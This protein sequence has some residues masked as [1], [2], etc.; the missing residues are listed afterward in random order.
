MQEIDTTEALLSRFG[1]LRQVLWCPNTKTELSCVSLSELLPRL[2]EGQ[3][4]RVPA[5]ALGAFVSELAAV[6]YPIVGGIVS[7]LEQDALRLGEA[8]SAPPHPVEPQADVIKQ[9][10][11]EWYDDF[12]WKKNTN[13][14]Y[15]DTAL[16]SQVNLLG[17]GL[18]EAM[19]HL[20]LVG[21][22]SGGEFMLDAASGPIAHPEKLAYS[23]YYRSRICLDTSITALEEAETKIGA[24]DYCCLA[25]IC[26][27]PFR[28]NSIDGI[29]SGYTIQHIPESQQ[30]QAIM[31]L[32][33]VLRPAA[34]L[35]VIT[36]VRPNM[37]HRACFQC[38]RAVMKVFRI[39]GVVPQPSSAGPR[40]SANGAAP[41][42]SLYFMSHDW[43]WWRQIAKELA[44]HESVECM[45]LFQK[46]EY[47]L[48]FGD[49]A[50]IVSFVRA[51][52]T[53][54]PRLLARASA[55]CL[56]DFAKPPA[57]GES[58]VASS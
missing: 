32:V 24:K 8:D 21:R 4:A 27:L 22:L 16:F 39:L 40:Q 11:K 3:R 31:E 33:R 26:R 36:D 6:A 12:G 48:L 46:S 56:V 45:R 30:V 55:Y 14:K 7:F 23:W 53:C 13:G 19:S 17:H 52:E 54:F 42:H 9:S 20:S 18:Y 10:V 51:L 37:W 38:F 34:H 2:S 15:N 47:E 44:I 49:S 35:C 29:V 1:P 28:D 57:R 5:G 25:D 43:K 50:R 58:T 41:P